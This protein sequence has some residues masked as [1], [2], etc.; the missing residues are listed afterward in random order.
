M[1]TGTGR[2]V[3]PN[4]QVKNRHHDFSESEKMSSDAEAVPVP[5]L[6]SW[7]GVRPPAACAAV[8]RPARAA[9][10]MVLGGARTALLSALHCPNRGA[11]ERCRTYSSLQ[12][13]N[14]R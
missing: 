11:H 1:L 10:P 4:A 8:F 7:R 2:S 13:Q 3:I 12:Q 6:A 9:S 5:R 14:T